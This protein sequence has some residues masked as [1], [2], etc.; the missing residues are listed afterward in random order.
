MPGM[1]CQMQ[2][3]KSSRSTPQHNQ[4]SYCLQYGD[5]RGG[6]SALTHP[7]LSSET[8]LVASV[9]GERRAV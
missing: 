2:R 3:V 1:S 8:R 6:K 9:S 4:D 7:F 5:V